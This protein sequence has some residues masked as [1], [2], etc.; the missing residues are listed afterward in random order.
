MGDSGAHAPALPHWSVDR[1]SSQAGQQVPAGDGGS[2]TGI[3]A[4]CPSCLSLLRR[5]Y[6][7]PRR[8]KWELEGRGCTMTHS[9]T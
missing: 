5:K 4:E 2:A 9:D 1:K 3:W 6:D 7:L 8:K